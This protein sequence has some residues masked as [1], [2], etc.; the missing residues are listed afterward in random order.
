MLVTITFFGLPKLATGVLHFFSDP[1]EAK[2]GAGF[3]KNDGKARRH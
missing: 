3:S 2:G 1:P